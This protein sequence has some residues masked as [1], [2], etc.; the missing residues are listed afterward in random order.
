MGLSLNN[1]Y[2]R[3]YVKQDN[4]NSVKKREQDEKSAAANAQREQESDQNSKSK[5]LQYVEQKQSIYTPA[6]EQKF[7]MPAQNAYSGVNIN[8]PHREIKAQ[9]QQ[10]APNP[11]LGIINNKINIAQ[12]LKDFKNTALAIG[13]PDELNDIVDGYLAVVEKQVKKENADSKIIKTTLK[14]A[15]TVLDKHISETLNKESSVVENWVE[16]LFMQ[17]ID[18][19]YNEEDINERFLVKFPDGSTSQTKRQEELH[20]TAQE[21]EIPQKVQDNPNVIPISVAGQTKSTKIP[22][23]KQ[24]K[25]LF[26]QAKKYAYA[27]NPEKAIKVFEQALNRALEIDDTETS[28]KIYYEVGKIYDDHDYI[29]QALKSYNQ[30]IQL[31][32]DEN[33]K[34]KAH[35]SMAQ[36]YDDVNQITPAMDHYFSTV[37]HAGEAENL[38]AQ[39]ASLT[40]LGNIYTDMYDKEAFTYYDVANDLAH[41]TKNPNLK[42]FVASNT[43][44]AYTKFEEPEKALKSYSKAVKN[45]TDAESHLKTAQNYLAAAD[46][47]VE[48]NNIEKAYNLLQKAQRYSRRTENVNLMNEINTKIKQLQQLNVK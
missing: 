4:R 12:I 31:S 32:E 20:A 2:Q 23:D 44:K 30:S 27:N 42:G 8:T 45:Y 39:S 17:N 13:T 3:P 22:Q 33:V 36:I 14:S 40:K 29:A 10:A 21:A 26:I 48:F 19:K 18:L 6:Y 34:T 28:G 1:I 9:V 11:N 16:T 47:M 41:E 15:A 38:P 5:G 43:G 7:S 24:L 37:S 25:S 35:Y 46:I